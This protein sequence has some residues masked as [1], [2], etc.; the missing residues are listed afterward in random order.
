MP[1]CTRCP[2]GPPGNDAADAIHHLRQFHPDLWADPGN[3]PQRWPD[4]RWA[5]VDLTL[6]PDDFKE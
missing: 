3:R 4:G 2:D 6:T 5:W 1:N